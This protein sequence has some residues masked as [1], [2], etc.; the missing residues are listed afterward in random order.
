MVLNAKLPSRRVLAVL[1]LAAPS[2]L[3]TRVVAG[4]D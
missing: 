1:S 3:N 4:E 2:L